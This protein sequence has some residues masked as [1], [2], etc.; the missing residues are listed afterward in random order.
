ME[1]NI[2]EMDFEEYKISDN[3]IEANSVKNVENHIAEADVDNGKKIFDA[4]PKKIAEKFNTF[5][6]T[7]CDRLKNTYTK[8]EVDNEIIRRIEVTGGGD[9]LKE[10]YAEEEENGNFSDSMVK[11][12]KR[13][14]NQGIEHFMTKENFVF[15]ET[16]QTLNITL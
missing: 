11:N 15:D 4:L 7:V 5:V 6:K 14:D 1:D 3:E 16:T 13:L 9:M 12:S 2:T 8:T 10:K